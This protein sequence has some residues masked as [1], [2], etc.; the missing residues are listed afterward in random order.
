MSILVIVPSL[1]Y[2]DMLPRMKDWLDSVPFDRVIAPEKGYGYAIQKAMI[3]NPDYD[4]YL[5]LDSDMAMNPKHIPQ[6]I[7]LIQNG[8]DVVVGTRQTREAVVKRT[9][10]RAKVSKAYNQWCS[11]LFDS[12]LT[13]HLCGFRAYSGRVVRDCIIP[14]VVESH[15]IWQCE[16]VVIPQIMGYAVTEIP[17]EWVEFRYNRTP[18]RRL[19]RDIYQM[20]IRTFK[21]WVRWRYYTK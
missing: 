14:Y 13:E 7:W 9:K 1:S 8:W 18:I 16:T 11:M 20:G 6:M 15:W 5:V 10:L 17:I 3:N 19:V 21:L 2:S 12:E 4:I